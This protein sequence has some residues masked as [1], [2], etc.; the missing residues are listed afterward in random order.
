MPVSTC[1]WCGVYAHMTPVTPVFV[2]PEAADETFTS[3]VALKC[4][5]CQ[6]LSVV[7]GKHWGKEE[8]TDLD[9]WAQNLDSFSLDW[10]PKGRQMM[11][12]EGVPNNIELLAE[13]A[14]LCHE[15]GAKVGAIATANAVFDATSVDLEVNCET[16]QAT[17]DQ[18]VHEGFIRPNLRELLE[19]WPESYTEGA[20]VSWILELMDVTLME[21]YRSRRLVLKIKSFQKGRRQRAEERGEEAPDP[22]I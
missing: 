19:K 17:F 6:K 12:Y 21:I 18:L 20:F 1:G 2:A 7:H 5:S 14:W 16:R 11:G 10:K 4:D 3:C 9:A 22:W 13:Q 8:E 15:A